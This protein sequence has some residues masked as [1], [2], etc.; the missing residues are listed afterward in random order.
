MV[1][2]AHRAERRSPTRSPASNRRSSRRAS[3][4][5]EMQQQIAEAIG[6]KDAGIFDAHLLVVEDHTL[7]DEV[8]RKLEA[9]HCNVEFAFQEVASRYVEIAQRDRRSLPARARARHPGCHPP[10]HSQS[11]GKSA[12][13]VLSIGRTA[14]PRR[15]T[16]SRRPTPRTMNR[17][18]VLGLRHRSRQPHLAHR[19]HGAVV[20]HSR[21]RR[22]ARRRPR[23]SRPAHHVLLDGY[24]GL[25]IVNPSDRD[26]AGYDGEF[27][28]KT[29]R[30]RGA[31]NRAARNQIDHPRRAAHRPFRQ[32][33]V[34]RRSGSCPE[35]TGPKAS[36]FIGRNFSISITKRCRPK[37]NNSKIT[38]W[39]PNGSR[40]IRVIIRTLD[41]GGDKIADGTGGCRRG[42]ESLP[43]L[44]GDPFLPRE[45]RDFQGAAARD[46]AG[47]RGRQCEDDVSHDLRA[48]RSAARPT[49]VVRGM[50]GRVAP[51]KAR[52]LTRPWKS[53]R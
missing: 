53:A 27:E 49:Q 10:R 44:A 17:A 47:E 36:A 26:A 52:L 14:H 32:H 46:L 11:A 1:K 33:R 30:D 37:R 15:R 51:R 21:R 5:L 42:D 48:R 40:R 50:Q 39:S 23:N 16:I 3:Q 43:G 12:A 28:R 35:V 45:S 31:T 34:A 25:L 8:L 2:Y 38:G 6:A 24:N 13:A 7:I 22:A 9:D 19:D 41:L 29:G 4:I 20:R 18:Q